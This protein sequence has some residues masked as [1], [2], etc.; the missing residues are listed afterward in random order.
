VPSRLEL[1][2]AGALA[3]L[4]SVVALGALRRGLAT[5]AIP[6]AERGVVYLAVL[7]ATVVVLRRDCLP[8]LLAGALAGI[9]G[10]ELIGLRT[11]LLAA[12]ASANPEEGRLLFEPVGYA[13]AAGVLAAM[14]IVAAVGLAVS[15]RGTGMRV[16]AAA[17][18]TPLAAALA[19]TGSRGAV[20]SLLLAA[21]CVLAFE[22]DRRRLLRVCA[23][24]VPPQLAA[25]SLVAAT[26]V[27]DAHA[28][29][30]VVRHDG[31]V[32]A[33]GLALLS[34]TAGLAA[35]RFESGPRGGSAR[36]EIR[37]AQVLAFGGIL[38]LALLPATGLAGMQRAAFARA[39]W[40]D[41]TTHP[42]LGSGAGT[43]GR[44]WLEHRDV[45][46]PALDAH[47]IF[48]EAAA[49]L[50]LPGLLLTV[51]FAAVP[52]VGL[53]RAC[54]S[55]RS[56]AYLAG[57]YVLGVAHGTVDWDWEMPVV[58]TTV[59]VTGTALVVAARREGPRRP[60]PG[61]RPATL[62]FISA[63]A[64]CAAFLLAGEEALQAGRA[65]AGRGDWPAAERLARRASRLEPWSAA[66][67]VLAARSDL[68]QERPAAARSLLVHALEL[69]PGD[70]QT[71][72]VYGSLLDGPGR[73]RAAR[74]IARL[75]P[76][77]VRIRAAARPG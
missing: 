52:L 6:E 23:R 13:N 74:Q 69:D 12:P 5:V 53:G 35:V 76:S 7:V 46:V 62:V 10:V 33:V 40:R 77:A 27:T 30:A 51:L 60:R 8:A 50:G 29:L 66:P 71:W 22:A 25:A 54:S 18:S 68:A 16:L 3:A 28:A 11:L 42:W 4:L 63:L 75:D 55:S 20:A 70:W 41:F 31:R 26:H 67:L 47:G 9:V 45:A 64:A 48:A 15:S 39:A 24:I 72:F 43:F 17:A 49:E 14:G 1:G 37:A 32:V 73:S 38:T 34:V 36:R 58:T 2:L 65:A 21:G 19:A 44:F 56:A 57:M 61:A 59:V